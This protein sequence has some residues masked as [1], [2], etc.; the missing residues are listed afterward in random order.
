M[1]Q[2]LLC[3]LNLRHH[4]HVEHAEDGGL[5]TALGDLLDVRPVAC[6]AVRMATGETAPKM[7]G[8]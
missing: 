5:Y 3:K 4:W 2:A 1:I 8:R 6:A 7:A